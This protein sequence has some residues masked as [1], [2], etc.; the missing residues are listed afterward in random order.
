VVRWQWWLGAFA[1]LTLIAGLGAACSDDDGTGDSVSTAAGSTI[2]EVANRD[3]DPVATDEQEL[4]EEESDE[5]AESDDDSV[6]LSVAEIAADARP[7]V[8]HIRTEGGAGSG[9]VVDESGLIVTNNHVVSVSTFGGS[10]EAQQVTVTLWDGQELPATVLGRDPNTDL[11]LLQVD[12]DGLEALDLANVDEVRIGDPVVAIGFA[13]DLGDSPSVTTGVVSAKERTLAESATTSLQGLLQTDA[14]INPGNSGGP[15]IDVHGDVVGVNTA[16]DTSGQGI[17]FAVSADTVAVVVDELR[18]H[19]AVAR[20]FIGITFQD[21]TPAQ[22]QEMGLDSDNG[23]VIEEVS[24]GTPA[25]DAGL[26]SG[27][28]IVAVDGT[29]IVNGS[30]LPLALIGHPA[31]DTITLTVIRDGDELDIDVVLGERPETF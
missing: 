7:S 19:G 1:S 25:E 6:L 5:S 26:Q 16:I 4:Q 22:A 30:D 8:V 14:A 3:E 24:P 13:L 9:F 27:D 12:A 15:L 17:G 20:G 18:E 28:V 31:G 29:E 10:Q 23:V 21:L 11:A 2:E